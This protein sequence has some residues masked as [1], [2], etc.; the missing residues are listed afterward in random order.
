MKDCNESNNIQRSSDE[1]CP[2]QNIICPSKCV[3]NWTC[4]PLH[5]QTV[6]NS[7]FSYTT[8]PLI[9]DV[10]Q[11]SKE[12][13]AFNCSTNIT[14][15]L[16]LVNDLVSDCGEVADDEPI[17]KDLLANHTFHQCRIPGEIPC[18]Y[19]YPKCYNLSDICIFNLNKHGHLMPCRTGSHLQS[20]KNFECNL[21]FKCPQFYCIPWAYICDGKWD[22][23]Y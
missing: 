2:L 9:C 21:H 17:Y 11:H 3:Q 1:S 22:C 18:T 13:K 15:D 10:K 16:T 20:Y 4:S 19:S 12:S 7:C 23:P 14:I 6:S 5:Y 8:L